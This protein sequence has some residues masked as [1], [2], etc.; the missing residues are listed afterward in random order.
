MKKIAIILIGIAFIL[1]WVNI[2]AAAPKSWSC[3]GGCVGDPQVPLCSCTDKSG[4]PPGDC[5]TSCEE[6]TFT[7]EPI[8]HCSY[9]CLIYKHNGELDHEEM[10]QR[11]CYGRECTCKK[12]E[13]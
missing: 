8:G 7:T 6:S 9:S 1:S 10:G 12:K 13:S 2:F 3:T 11:N 4:T 5:V